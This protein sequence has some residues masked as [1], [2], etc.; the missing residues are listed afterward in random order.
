MSRKKEPPKKVNSEFEVA[1]Q[2]KERK[3]EISKARDIVVEK[4]LPLFKRESKNETPTKKL[5]AFDTKLRVPPKSIS[6]SLISQSV[7][8][9]TLGLE[10]SDKVMCV[11]KED[12]KHSILDKY[13]HLKISYV[14]INRA[15]SKKN[16]EG[17]PT[18]PPF[19]KEDTMSERP[20][21]EVIAQRYELLKK[22]HDEF[23]EMNSELDGNPT[24]GDLGKTDVEPELKICKVNL[25]KTTDEFHSLKE[26]ENKIET[27]S[28]T[29]M[30]DIVKEDVTK[31]EV[32]HK[33]LKMNEQSKM[34]MLHVVKKSDLK[35][36]E[37]K[38]D[39]GGDTSKKTEDYGI[40]KEDNKPGTGGESNMMHIAEQTLKNQ[41]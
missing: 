8:T 7:E 19:Q 9:T 15:S 24:V 2:K 1:K 11:G 40:L 30:L 3:E 16:E 12:S 17:F 13:K 37:L 4:S 6:K 38:K 5:S 28:K 34:N 25:P 14:T 33:Q 29:N 27:E 20:L 10:P 18:L 39:K 41:M 21:P 32:K 31:E 26:E 22:L 36:S 23:N 35:T